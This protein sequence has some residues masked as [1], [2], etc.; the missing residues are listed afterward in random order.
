MYMPA[1]ARCIEANLVVWSFSSL[2]SGT[3]SPFRLGDFSAQAA[4]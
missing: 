3:P 2:E 4:Q 1:T